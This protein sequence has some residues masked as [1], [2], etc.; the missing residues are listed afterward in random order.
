MPEKKKLFIM[1]DKGFLILIPELL[2]GFWICY[3]FI[4]R[5]PKNG[6]SRS[7]RMV[8][9]VVLFCFVFC[10]VLFC[11][12]LFLVKL[13]SFTCLV[14]IMIHDLL[15]WAKYNWKVLVILLSTFSRQIYGLWKYLW[16]FPSKRLIFFTFFSLFSCKVK[17]NRKN[18]I[19]IYVEK[20]R[21]LR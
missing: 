18:D 20:L 11:F 1:W 8:G 3:F 15:I 5:I 6:T 16:Q 7:N 21:F 12:V 17:V 4:N 19:K 2:K 13:K 9:K 14:L 10:F